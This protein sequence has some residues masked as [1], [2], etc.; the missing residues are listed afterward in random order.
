MS[1]DNKELVQAL[2]KMWRKEWEAAQAYRLVAGKEQDERRRNILT[3]LAEV[4]E[5][6]AAQWAA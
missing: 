4:E 6:H 3:K 1:A 5:G 2:Q